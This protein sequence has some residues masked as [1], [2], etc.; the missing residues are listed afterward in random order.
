MASPSESEV[1][2]RV[3]SILYHDGR[4]V[5]T[6]DRSIAMEA[7]FLLGE[8]NGVVSVCVTKKA[9]EAGDGKANG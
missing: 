7:M 8:P 2:A 1:F 9:K 4:V 5:V 3:W 6:E